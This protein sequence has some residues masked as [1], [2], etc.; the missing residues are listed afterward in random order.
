MTPLDVSYR[1]DRIPGSAE[2]RA[3]SALTEVYGIRKVQFHEQT[4]TV[5]LEYDASRLKEDAVTALLRQAG[6]DIKEKLV[7]A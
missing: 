7:A 6:L 3:I 4:R 5:R 2:L 1:Y